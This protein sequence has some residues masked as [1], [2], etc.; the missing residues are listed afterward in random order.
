M[1]QKLEEEMRAKMENALENT[2]HEFSRVRTGRASVTLLDGIKVSY[3][4]SVVPLN[5]VAT[6]AVPESRL[7][8][9]QPWDTK[10]IGDIEKA[11][12]KSDLGLTPINDGKIIRIPIPALTE[13]RR[14]E[15]VKVIKNMAEKVKVALRSI[16]REIND[17]LKNLKKDKEISEDE[18]FTHHDEVQKITDE[19]TVRADEIVAVKEKELMEI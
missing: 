19:Y 9:L 7:I 5:Q 18:Y 1:I 2:R 11:I 3:Y 6:L 16:R 13:E 12:L 8:T 4:G 15:L 14:K 10:V 17:N